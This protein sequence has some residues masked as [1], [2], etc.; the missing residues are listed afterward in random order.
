VI[1]AGL[2]PS[3]TSFGVALLESDRAEGYRV[4]DSEALSPPKGVVGVERL[5]WFR[6]ALEDLIGGLDPDRDWVVLEGYAFSRVNLTHLAEVVSI[7]KLLAWDYRLRVLVASPSG[8]KKFVTG[9]GN[10]P[11]EVMRLEAYKRFG[12]EADTSDEVEAVLLALMGVYAKTQ[13]R[14]LL[15]S[16]P[17]ANLEGLKKL[18]VLF[19]DRG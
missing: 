12:V 18:E 7:V 14:G 19:G 9:K 15:P 3:V 2:D 1:V 6:G 11:K 5:A 13:E 4:V 10:A 17:A 8:L 16:L